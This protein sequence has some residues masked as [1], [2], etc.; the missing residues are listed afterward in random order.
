MRRIMLSRPGRRTDE[1]SSTVRFM[2]VAIHQP[3]FLPWLGYFH[4]LLRSHVFVLLDDVQFPRGKSFANRVQIKTN[5]GP[6]WI[7]VPVLDRSDLVPIRDARIARDPSWKRKVVRTMELNYAKA[8]YTKQ[9]LPGLSE[10]ID[11]AGDNLCSLNSALIAW[12][13][14]QL[15]AETQ[16]QYSSDLCRNQPTLGGEEK[17]HHLLKATRA[18]QYVSGDGAGSRRYIKEEW[19]D[20]EGIELRWQKFAH[21]RYPQLHGAFAEKLSVIDLIFNCGPEARTVLLSD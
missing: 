20:Q 6:G 4:K 13:A 9:Y 15:N 5:Q 14:K 18:T 11:A 12:C 7:T 2:I 16:I 21:P 1:L 3:N 10:I 17:I 19:F 8:P